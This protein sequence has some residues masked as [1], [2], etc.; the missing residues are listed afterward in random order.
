MFE[1]KPQRKHIDVHLKT[2]ILL[3][4]YGLPFAND[5]QHIMV[6]GP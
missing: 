6:I 5:W 3:R 4:R 2:M 1:T